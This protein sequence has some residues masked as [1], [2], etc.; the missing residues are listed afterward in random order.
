MLCGAKASCLLHVHAG[1]CRRHPQPQITEL[2]HEVVVID[3]PL[4]GANPP[5]GL[6]CKGRTSATACV[7]KRL[8]HDRTVMR[9]RL[10]SHAVTC[11]G[12]PPGYIRRDHVA[13]GALVSRENPRLQQI[14]RMKRTVMK[15]RPRTCPCR[16]D[17]I[18]QLRH[19][20]R[21]CACTAV[22]LRRLGFTSSL[23]YLSLRNKPQLLVGGHKTRRTEQKR[24]LPRRV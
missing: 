10:R 3:S 9:I 8:R 14:S 4:V 5:V 17:A 18:T 20:L 11:L 1:V 16:N 7:A 12:Q 21:G 13:P 24:V 15:R 6:R 23:P 19:T 22:A 2:A